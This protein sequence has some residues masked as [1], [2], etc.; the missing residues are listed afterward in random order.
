MSSFLLLSKS[1]ASRQESASKTA[2]SYIRETL[3]FMPP[4]YLKLFRNTY[5]YF[6]KINFNPTLNWLLQK[7]WWIC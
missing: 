4:I 3:C 1:V 6:F 5:Y 2:T 7:I